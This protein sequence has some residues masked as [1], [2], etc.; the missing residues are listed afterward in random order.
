MKNLVAQTG[1]YTLDF[2]GED[3]LSVFTGRE[4][5]AARRPDFLSALG[6]PFENLVLLKQIHSANL[7]LVK[8]R[9]RPDEQ[10]QADGMLTTAEGI[11]LGILTADCVPVYFWDAEKRVIGLAHAGWRGIYHQIAPKMVQA[12]K[13]NFNSKPSSIRVMFGPSIRKCCYEVGAEF[14]E[15]FPDFFVKIPDSKSGDGEIKGHMELTDAL[16]AQLAEEGI[17]PENIYDSSLC[18][19]C[20]NDRY[21]SARKEQGSSE[22]ILSVLMIRP[23]N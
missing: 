14:S 8:S 2:F 18:T 17:A 1:V 7:V 13:Q 9:Q 11:V 22:R 23:K 6:Q 16:R 10:C 21:F 5:T 19:S 12:F 15:Y 3:V 20:Q 4:F